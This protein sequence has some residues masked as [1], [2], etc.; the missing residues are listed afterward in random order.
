MQGHVHPSLLPLKVDFTFLPGSVSL[1]S[2]FCQFSPSAIT[3]SQT[4]TKPSSQQSTP[5]NSQTP[6]LRFSGRTPLFSRT[7]YHLFLFTKHKPF[8]FPPS[9]RQAKLN[10][11]VPTKRKTCPPTPLRPSPPL[12]LILLRPLPMLSMMMILLPLR[13]KLAKQTPLMLL[14][15]LKAGDFTSGTLLTLLLRSS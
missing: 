6:K 13:P 12:L 8:C 4:S 2:V 3:P 1:L 9:D 15:L 14:L 11:Q 5:F 10:R 7:Q